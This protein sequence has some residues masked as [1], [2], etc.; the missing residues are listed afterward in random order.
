M[1]TVVSALVCCLFGL[2]PSRPPSPPR[3]RVEI[4]FQ[5]LPMRPR[6]A[7]AAM[8]EVTAIWA[9]YGVDVS[10]ASSM[11]A[12]R[13][14]AL[15][16]AVVLADHQSGNIPRS[17]LGSA[18]FVGSSPQPTIFMYPHTIAELVS[19]TTV[20]GR[21]E[22]QWTI[23]FRDRILGRAFGRALAHE[24]GHVL[25][26]SRV[27]PTEGLMRARYSVIDLVLPDLHGFQL[28]TD[29]VMRLTFLTAPRFVASP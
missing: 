26:R 22:D 17:A 13:S 11:D 27:H 9:S 16:L 1:P 24:I 12:G 28:L 19:T 10:E 6:M 18:W 15:K 25:L 23:S 20:F 8:E 4:V 21:R 14:G 29:E 5:G 7:D 2:S 3:L